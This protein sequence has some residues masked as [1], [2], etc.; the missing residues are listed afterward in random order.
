MACFNSDQTFKCDE[1]A[2]KG[3]S[4]KT[5]SKN[6]NFL[7]KT[8]DIVFSFILTFQWLMRI[9]SLTNYSKI[10]S[11]SEL[12]FKKFRIQISHRS[13][14]L[15]LTVKTFI[16]NKIRKALEIPFN[17]KANMKPHLYRAISLNW[18]ISSESTD[19]NKF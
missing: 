8:T 5:F 3:L 4:I 2:L 1:K 15:N 9:F 10:V 13:H 11:K 19:R 14:E 12:L 16:R 18:P 6:Y 7:F 17:E